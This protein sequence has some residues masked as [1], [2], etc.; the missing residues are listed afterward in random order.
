MPEPIPTIWYSNPKKKATGDLRLYCILGLY[1]SKKTP[2]TAKVGLVIPPTLPDFWKTFLKECGVELSETKMNEAKSIFKLQYHANIKN[3]RDYVSK[4][5]AELNDLNMV[6][7]VI[8][9]ALQADS[10]LSTMPQTLIIHIKSKAYRGADS[11]DLTDISETSNYHEEHK[12]SYTL[13]LALAILAAKRGV[14][15]YINDDGKRSIPNTNDTKYKDALDLISA[16]E[17]RE[18]C[19]L[20]KPN[21]LPVMAGKIAL[22]DDVVNKQTL[23][24]MDQYKAIAKLGTT[25]VVHIGGRSG[26]LEF[27]IYLG[28]YVYYCEEN[29]ASGKDRIGT[30]LTTWLYKG[31]NLMQRI[32]I[33]PTTRGGR[34]ERNYMETH[35]SSKYPVGR[36]SPVKS[37]IPR[38]AI[39][40]E[41]SP[42]RAT[43]HCEGSMKLRDIDLNKCDALVAFCRKLGYCTSSN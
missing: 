24:M 29:D 36:N 3:P 7:P 33:V 31:K 15:V 10:T 32:V 35:P 17:K 11:S 27:M 2:Q 38:T 12:L 8:R 30:T 34:Y 19:S 23:S 26:H 40:A 39:N 21:N 25:N 16:S 1:H 37:R 28:Q 42:N 14:H 18:N 13:C 41:S 43:M 20:Q 9:R 6:I 22:I 5:V 4:A